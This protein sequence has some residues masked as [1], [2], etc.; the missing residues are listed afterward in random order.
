MWDWRTRWG[1]SGQTMS[2]TTAPIN[3]I[4]RWNRRN[5]GWCLFLKEVNMLLNSCRSQARW[6][7]L[8]LIW[9]MVPLI[10]ETDIY[11][12]G[13]KICLSS[14]TFF[15]ASLVRPRQTPRAWFHTKLDRCSLRLI[16]CLNL[17]VGLAG[18][19][20][21]AR[22]SLAY[23]DSVFISIEPH[24]MRA[25]VWWLKHWAHSSLL[26]MI[27]AYNQQNSSSVQLA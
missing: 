10:L 8:V 22:P 4:D 19:V 26:C 18:A 12:N 27:C 23:T 3:T 6:C 20:Q 2:W 11:I 21:K 24:S 5:L 1:L 25:P 9:F 13:N 15:A 7:W 16:R 14:S 17:L